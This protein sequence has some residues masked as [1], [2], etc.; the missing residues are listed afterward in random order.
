MPE[1]F[2]MEES[3][4]EENFYYE[5]CGCIITF[6][7]GWLYRERSERNAYWRSNWNTFCYQ[8][9]QRLCGGPTGGKPAQ[10]VEVN[11]EGVVA[12]VEDDTITL[13]DGKII[14][15]TDETSFAS[16]PDSDRTISDEIAVGN[17]IQGYTTDDANADKVTASNIWTNDAPTT[18]GKMAVNFEG[19]VAAVEDGKVTLE[20]GTVILTD[21][22]D[23][24]APDGSAGKISAGD[25]IQGYAE[26]PDAAELNATAILITVL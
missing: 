18:G 7:A 15:I 16:D 6:S 20:D 10:K 13:A 19:R 25:Y 12:A 3:N 14:V 4:Y 22:A 5:P 1:H 8:T 2:I 24:A 21:G 17:Y 23:I 9:C 26:D 11:F